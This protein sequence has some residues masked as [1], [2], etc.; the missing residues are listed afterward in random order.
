MAALPHRE[1]TA[2]AA[3]M[4][5]QPRLPL[6]TFCTKALGLRCLIASRCLR[7]VSLQAASKTTRSDRQGRELP[8]HSKGRNIALVNLPPASCQP[9]PAP[10][11]CTPTPVFHL[12]GAVDAGAAGAAVAAV[13]KAVAV[14]LEAL[15]LLAVALLRAAQGWARHRAAGWRVAAVKAART[16]PPVVPDD[17][18]AQSPSKC[19]PQA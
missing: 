9:A 2:K 19:R 15:A 12:V 17:G 8:A 3:S 11:S 4:P 7:T 16:T 10:L 6:L 5:P 14:Q 18:S 1:N 13:G